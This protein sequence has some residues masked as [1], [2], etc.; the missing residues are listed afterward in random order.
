M[1]GEGFCQGA[2]VRFPN[3]RGPLLREGEGRVRERRGGRGPYR[4]YFSATSSPG[5]NAVSSPAGFS[6]V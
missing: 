3:L 5:R 1:S 4:L 6:Y 2:Y